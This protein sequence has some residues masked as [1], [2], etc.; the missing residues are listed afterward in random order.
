MYYLIL[1][2]ILRKGDLGKAGIEESIFCSIGLILN[3]RKG[4]L[5]F[6]EGF[7]CDLWEWEF[8]DIYR[9]NAADIRKSV[10]EAINIYEPRLNNIDVSIPQKKGERTKRP[11]GL[12]LVVAGT[13]VDEGRER[14]FRREFNIG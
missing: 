11:L 1:P 12:G 7:G 9:V 4:S 10:R 13:F 5:P 6:D 2:L 3:T 8:S 14:N